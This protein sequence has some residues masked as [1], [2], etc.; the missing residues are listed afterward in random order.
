MLKYNVLCLFNMVFKRKR[1]SID[2]R[3][4]FLKLE[5]YICPLSIK[6]DDE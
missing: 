6:S 4:S 2:N 3:K 1:S 5:N